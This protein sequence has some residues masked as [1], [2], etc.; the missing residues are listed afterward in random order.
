VNDAADHP[1][2][3]DPTRAR[4]IVWQQRLN[5]R[6]LLI[7]EPKLPC[8]LQSSVVSEL[9]SPMANKFNALIEF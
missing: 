4:L 1:P 7:T 6:P 3:I 5:R 9:E 8:H 2:I